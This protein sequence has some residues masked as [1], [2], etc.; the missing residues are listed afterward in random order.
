MAAGTWPIADASDGGRAGER[1]AHLDGCAECREE[2]EAVRA[3]SRCLAELPDVA[4]ERSIADA[5]MADVDLPVPW[6]DE[7]LE[8]LP[9]ATPSM[10]F[11]AAVMSRVDLPAPWLDEV[12]AQLPELEPSARFRAAVLE[13]VDLPAP[14]LSAALERVPQTAPDPGFATRVMERVRLPVPWHQRFGR[15]VRRRRVA[16]A[17][18]AGATLATSAAGAGWL[19]GIQGVTPAQFVMFVLDGL[20]QLAVSGLLAVGE[21]G[22]ELGLVDAGSAITDI[23]PVAALGSLALVGATGL[24]S[25]V[26]MARLMRTG[27][28]M[29]L[30]EGTDTARG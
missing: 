19:F 9:E 12:L 13:R 6:L 16:L 8:T 22:Y 20:R 23:S 28:A 7:A 3:L 15:F 10:G 24:A 26:V 18:A 4:P 2:V 14:W 11:A 30:V 5:V 25:L 1:F 27:P 21:L 29:R 17:G